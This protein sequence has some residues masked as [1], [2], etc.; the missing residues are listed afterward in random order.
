M[1]KFII[2][3]HGDSIPKYRTE[4]SVSD[5]LTWMNNLRGLELL[6]LKL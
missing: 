5:R 2:I 4:Q 3:L 1:S 6:V